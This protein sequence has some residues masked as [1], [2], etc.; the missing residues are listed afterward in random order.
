LIASEEV[1]KDLLLMTLRKAMT[2]NEPTRE[3]GENQRQLNG[4]VIGYCR[5]TD[6][7]VKTST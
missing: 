5:G 4:R 3:I 7:I 6:I 1:G 2:M